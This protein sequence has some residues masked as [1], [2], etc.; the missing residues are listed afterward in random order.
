[1]TNTRLFPRLATSTLGVPRTL[2]WPWS[3][4][5]P[6]TWRRWTSSARSPRSCFSNLQTRFPTGTTACAQSSGWTCPKTCPGLSLQNEKWVETLIPNLARPTRPGCLLSSPLSCLTFSF[7]RGK[8]NCSHSTWLFLTYIFLLW[9]VLQMSPFPP[10][11]APFVIKKD[12]APP[13]HHMDNK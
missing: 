12:P 4:T 2:W 6:S 5:Y 3:Q 7:F 13:L 9:T 1:M 8:R 10:P 11:L